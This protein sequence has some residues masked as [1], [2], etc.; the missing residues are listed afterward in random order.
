MTRYHCVSFANLDEG[1]AFAAALSR[2]LASPG[3]IGR[4]MPANSSV[5]VRVAPSDDLRGLRV[6]L[7]TAALEAAA[8]AFGAPDVIATG[9]LE[10][11]PSAGV[12]IASGANRVPYGKDDIVNRILN[13][14]ATRA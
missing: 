9:G 5:E 2:F 11:L 12:T 1:A 14:E 7:S 10:I 3:G 8:E 4:A 6:F 13:P